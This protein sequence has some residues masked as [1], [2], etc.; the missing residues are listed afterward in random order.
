MASIE[1]AIRSADV[2]VFS[3]ASCPY[4]RRAREALTS[5]GIEHRVVEVDHRTRE[6][7][8]HITGRTTVPAVFVKGQY[9]GGCNDG[10]LGGTL[11]LLATGQLKA[12]LASESAF[13]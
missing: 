11:P 4:C 2:V 13:S 1:D 7:L 6:A 10:G 3:S 9:V 8:T 12:M 5:H